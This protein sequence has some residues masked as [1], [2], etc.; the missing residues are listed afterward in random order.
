MTTIKQGDS[1]PRTV[2]SNPLGSVK[3]LPAFSLLAPFHLHTPDHC[4]G[5][6]VA[7]GNKANTELL[8]LS[9]GE[10]EEV[11]LL[12]TSS[13][14]EHCHVINWVHVLHSKGQTRPT[15]IGACALGFAGR[16]SGSHM[17]SLIYDRYR[18]GYFLL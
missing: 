11:V 16:P 9:W 3:N 7:H 10:W 6:Q 17:G 4:S 8:R 14:E 1:A 13:R 12:G 15:Q 2:E 5:L 18:S